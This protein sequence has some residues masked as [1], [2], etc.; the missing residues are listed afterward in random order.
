MNF[1][2]QTEIFCGSDCLAEIHLPSG[3]MIATTANED[4]GSWRCNVQPGSTPDHW[5][6]NVR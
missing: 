3:L 5:I 6:P 4:S 2:I 1:K